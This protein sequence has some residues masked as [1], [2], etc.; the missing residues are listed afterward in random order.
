MSQ[1]GFMK[2]TG[3]VMSER[4]MVT[5]V[6]PQVMYTEDSSS[7]EGLMVEASM[8][9]ETERFMMET[10]RKESNQVE[11]SGRTQREINILDSGKIQKHME[12]AFICGVMEI[13]TKEIGFNS[14]SMGMVLSH[15]QMGTHTSVS[16]RKELL[17][18]KELTNGEMDRSMWEISS[19]D[20]S[21]GREIG[22]VTE[23]P[24]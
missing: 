9:G 7:E 14:K 16:I 24:R 4:E 15:S 10:G 19:K 23:M 21:M 5:S 3:R 1:E 2:E 13:D 11:D 18:E 12:L 8:N 20:L 17:M 22:R 6:T